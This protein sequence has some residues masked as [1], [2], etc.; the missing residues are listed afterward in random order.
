MTTRDQLITDNMPLIWYT[1]NKYF[2]GYED[3]EI[4]EEFFQ[5]GM[6]GLLEAANSFEENRN[7]KFSTYAIKC[8]RRKIMRY[9]T[10]INTKKRKCNFGIISLNQ[11]MFQNDENDICLVDRLGKEEDYST[12]NIEH[13]LQL[14]EDTNIKNAKYIVIKRAEGYSFRE[15]GE[16]LGISGRAVQGRI[17]TISKMLSE[18]KTVNILK[19]NN[20]G[21]KWTDKEIDFLKQEYKNKGAKGIADEL[22]RSLRAVENRVSKLGLKKKAS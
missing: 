18:F 5:E 17:D 6:F 16:S 8:I 20:S 3:I 2:F 9:L 4:Q 11:V 12:V 22:G 7:V 15:I 13:I 1:I 19:S 14:V 10:Y 21:K